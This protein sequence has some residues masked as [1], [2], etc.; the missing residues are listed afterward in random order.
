MMGPNARLAT[1][2][3]SLRPDIDVTRRAIERLVATLSSDP[4]E[5]EAIVS[6]AAA[7]ALASLRHPS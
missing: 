2:L 7:E 1:N 6:A 4:A 3:A 5:R